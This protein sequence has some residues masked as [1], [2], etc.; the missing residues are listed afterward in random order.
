MHMHRVRERKVVEPGQRG[1]DLLVLPDDPDDAGLTRAIHVPFGVEPEAKLTL[2]GQSQDWLVEVHPK[3][4]VVQQIILVTGGVERV[5]D[6]NRHGFVRS[7]GGNFQQWFGG[8]E[9]LVGALEPVFGE[10]LHLAGW[11]FFGV[12]IFIV[13]CRKAVWLAGEGAD[14]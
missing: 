6:L 8:V 3:G 5:E 4:L 13:D 2:V 9:R 14:G 7:L 12:R 11:K 10:V 1:V